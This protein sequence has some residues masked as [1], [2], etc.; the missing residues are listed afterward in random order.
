MVRDCDKL[1]AQSDNERVD[2]IRR[3]VSGRGD[4]IVS[5]CARARV[6]VNVRRA[7]ATLD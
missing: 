4:A 2:E 3:D 7:R 6:V 5:A 1:E